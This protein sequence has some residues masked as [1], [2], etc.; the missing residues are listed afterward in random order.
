MI[1]ENLDKSDPPHDGCA[2]TKHKAHHSTLRNHNFFYSSEAPIM[3][4]PTND[5]IPELDDEMFLDDE[6]FRFSDVVTSHERLYPPVTPEH[7]VV[8][9]YLELPDHRATQENL[10]S[11]TVAFRKPHVIAPGAIDDSAAKIKLTNFI[12]FSI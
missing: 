8:V 3:S 9:P 5:S 1:L 11:M 6:T 2:Y 10:P 7:P 12:T 4:S